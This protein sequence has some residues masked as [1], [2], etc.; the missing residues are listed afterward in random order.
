MCD[1]MLPGWPVCRVKHRPGLRRVRDLVLHWSWANVQVRVG[2]GCVL[3]LAIP[4]FRC[5]TPKS[6]ESRWNRDRDSRFTFWLRQSPWSRLHISRWGE[7]SP[8]TL[9]VFS[10]SADERVVV[11]LPVDDR[12][13][14]ELD[15][16]DR[17][18]LTPNPVG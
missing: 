4:E 18:D 15:A 5:A 1:V 3:G 13:I 11:N 12:S 9:S 16:V 6:E 17:M 8:Q 7:L 2:R 14:S 10:N